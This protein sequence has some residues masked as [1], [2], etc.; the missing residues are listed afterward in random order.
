MNGRTG[1]LNGNV[2]Y[3]EDH[4]HFCTNVNILIMQV[5]GEPGFYG[6]S[7]ITANVRGGNTWFNFYE[8]ADCSSGRKVHTENNIT[9][10]CT[11]SALNRQ[12][13]ITINKDKTDVYWSGDDHT[14]MT[15]LDDEFGTDCYER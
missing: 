6:D 3:I 12:C 14:A 1:S 5:S 13:D 4:V 7:T 2:S 15:C 11:P 9:F 10:S 8:G